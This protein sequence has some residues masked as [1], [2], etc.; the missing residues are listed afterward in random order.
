MEFLQSK[1]L[2]GKLK[3]QSQFAGRWQ[4]IR[5]MKHEIRNKLKGTVEKTNPIFRTENECK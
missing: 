3:K 4:E 5:S 2:W 1:Q